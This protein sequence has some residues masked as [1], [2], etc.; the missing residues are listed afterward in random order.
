MNI[1]K[2]GEAKVLTK[3]TELGIQ[4]YLP[5][6]EGSSVDL[7]AEFNG[8]LNRIQVKST[9]KENNGT[10]V[11]SIC[12]TTIQKDRKIQ[13]HIYSADEIDYFALYSSITDEVYLLPIE[14]VPTKKFSLR[15]KEP[16]N[17]K[18]HKAE[19]Y[20]LSRIL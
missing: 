3:F 2:L 10:L 6:G 20:L 15:Y 9:E 17:S 8:K 13:K 4:V 19:D 1:G 7:I 5:F 18:S 14:E 16:Y 11:F 12:S